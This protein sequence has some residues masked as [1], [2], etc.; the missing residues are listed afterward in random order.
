MKPV[1]SGLP[2]QPPPSALTNM[3]NLTTQWQNGQLDKDG[4]MLVYRIYAF[5]C[6]RGCNAPRGMEMV[7]KC[8]GSD[9]TFY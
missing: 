9:Y 3:D 4:F 5:N 1:M 8:T 2:V 6:N 7:K